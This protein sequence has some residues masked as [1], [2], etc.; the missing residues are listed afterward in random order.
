MDICLSA[1]TLLPKT[2]NPFYEFG[3]KS[4]SVLFISDFYS[5]FDLIKC[6]EKGCKKL[7]REDINGINLK[8][9]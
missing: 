7:C 6:T 8:G 3:N 4:I 2:A 1:L 9:R 5:C